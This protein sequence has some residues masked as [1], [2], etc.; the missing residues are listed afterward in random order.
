M[1]YN[2]NSDYP[3]YL[4]GSA[5]VAK[6]L[7]CLISSDVNQLV[8]ISLEEF[9][10]LDEGS[11]CMLGLMHGKQREKFLKN[12][13]VAAMKWPIFVHQSAVVSDIANIGAGTVVYPLAFVGHNANLGTFNFISQY[14]SIGHN[15]QLG[16]NV[17]TSP[18]I[19][20]GGST[21]IGNNV[22]IGQSSSLRDKISV[23]DNVTFYMTSTVTRS[24]E[25]AG[26]Y[27]GNKKVTSIDI[28]N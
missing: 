9:N 7:A 12:S 18:K 24:I 17:V 8:E 21:T 10:S 19:E 15:S 25:I 14:V 5:T 28:Q 27:F 1:L 16:T 20:I 4:L 11:Q 22:Y 26:E 2:Y 3:L 23:C 6:E 13:M